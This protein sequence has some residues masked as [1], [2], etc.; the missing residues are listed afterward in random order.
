MGLALPTA[1][2]RTVGAAVDTGRI[3]L[4]GPPDSAWQAAAG[5]QQTSLGRYLKEGVMTIRVDVAPSVLS[6][7][8]DVTGADE[9]AS[10]GAS[11]STSG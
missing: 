1:S 10:I 3:A 9:E 8:L 2:S 5:W 11:R 6:W 7:A 4:R